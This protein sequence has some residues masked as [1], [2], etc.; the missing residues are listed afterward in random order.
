MI[1]DGHL[2]SFKGL[3]GYV[4]VTISWHQHWSCG[5]GINRHFTFKLSFKEINLPS[6]KRDHKTFIISAQ[7]PYILFT[8]KLFIS[9]GFVGFVD[10]NTRKVS[11]LKCKFYWKSQSMWTLLTRKNIRNILQIHT[12]KLLSSNQKHAV[13]MKF[14]TVTFWSKI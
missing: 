2:I 11:L 13:K 3:C 1:A 5:L 4:W 8:F 14:K 9:I 10:W 12:L 6:G 7:R